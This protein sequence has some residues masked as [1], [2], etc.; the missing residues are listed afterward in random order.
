MAASTYVIAKAGWSTVAEI[1][2]SNRK[3]ALLGR[4]TVA[5]DRTTIGILKD[6]QQCIEIQTEDLLHMEDI[7]ERLENFNYSF[8]HEYHNDDYEIAKKILFAYPEKKRRADF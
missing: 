7:L 2:L 4:D 3:S 5:E 8:E 1:L 6:R